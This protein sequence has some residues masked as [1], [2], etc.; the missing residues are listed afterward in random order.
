MKMCGSDAQVLLN[1][2]AQVSPS[3][4]GRTFAMGT[5]IPPAWV[6]HV[7]HDWSTSVVPAAY[8]GVPKAYSRLPHRV[9]KSARLL[10]SSRLQ[11]W[12]RCGAR[13]EHDARDRN[14]RTSFRNDDITRAFTF[15]F[16]LF[17]RLFFRGV[18]GAA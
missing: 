16:L 11:I 6:V 17:F 18:S 3:K 8:R 14:R 5:T 15:F 10:F 9:S 13:P 1:R 4:P 12:H 2:Q 7:Q